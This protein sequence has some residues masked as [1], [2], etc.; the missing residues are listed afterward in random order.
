M[1][2][3]NL[4]GGFE[5][6]GIEFHYYVNA[7]VGNNPVSILACCAQRIRRPRPV[8]FDVW[9]Q[10]GTRHVLSILDRQLFH[11]IRPIRVVRVYTSLAQPRNF[12]TYP[13]PLP[14]CLDGI[15]LGRHASA[16]IP[17]APGSI[18]TASARELKS[19]G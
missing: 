4:P 3:D 18:D 5:C 7:S 2:R 16:R 9:R 14:R 19:L 1:A 6:A 11:E 15:R 12:W 10:C 8:A 17:N 13:N